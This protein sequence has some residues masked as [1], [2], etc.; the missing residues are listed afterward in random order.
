MAGGDPVSDELACLECDKAKDECGVFGIY[1]PGKNVSRITYF[2]LHAL[3]HRGEESSGVAVAGGKIEV[4][5]GMGLVTEVFDDDILNRLQGDIGIGHV[6]YSMKS[7]SVIN[8]QPQVFRYPWGM[9]AL[10][11]NGNLTNSTD[12]MEDLSRKGVIFQSISNTEIM[13][14]LLARHYEGDIEEALRKVTCEIQGAYSLVVMT[15]NK[16]IGLRDPCGIRPLC[17]GDL[18]G[19]FVLA[20]E[21]CALNTVGAEFIRNISPGEMV[22]IDGG[23]LKSTSLTNNNRQAPCVFEYVYLARPDS[24]IDDINVNIAR[25]GFG[26]QLAQENKV[27]ADVVV[28]VPYSGTTAAL[29]YAQERG[30]PFMEGLIKNRYV[31]RT[32]IQPSQKLRDLRVRLKLNPV[33]EILEGKSI[34]MVD[35]SIVRGTTSRK[36]VKMVREAGA[37]KVHFVVSCPPIAHPCYYG[38][39]TT[40]RDELIA[41]RRNVEEIR[42]HIGADSL[43]YLSLRG[44]LEVLDLPEEKVCAACFTGKYPIDVSGCRACDNKS[45]SEKGC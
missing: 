24:T 39:K 25:F 6:R 20:S 21:S 11:Y 1:G 13:A 34:V 41:S 33:K 23:G 43:Y 18:D 27:D 12:L 3:Q 4:H 2:G 35:D 38:I 26:K 28:G 8:A 42:H 14:N 36:I 30:L 16:L 9:V 37:R 32:F 31:G 10:A 5:K 22:A 15:Q 7:N 44:M 40:S 17:L 19:S 45:F 29:G